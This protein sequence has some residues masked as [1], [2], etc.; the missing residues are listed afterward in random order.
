MQLSIEEIVFHCAATDGGVETRKF[1]LL[2]RARFSTIPQ[3]GEPRERRL[4]RFKTTQIAV[5][6]MR[7]V[8]KAITVAAENSSPPNRLSYLTP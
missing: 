5:G 3:L 4:R 2:D 1:N 8:Q 6:S 7:N